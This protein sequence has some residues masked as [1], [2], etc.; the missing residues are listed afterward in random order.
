MVISLVHRVLLQVSLISLTYITASMSQAPP[1]LCIV[2]LLT[3]IR[4]L[5]GMFF[6]VLMQHP[7]MA[8]GM[9]DKDG[10]KKYGGT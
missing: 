5:I 8:A 7:G 10:F 9:E 6:L 1:L 2:Y 3:F 4:T